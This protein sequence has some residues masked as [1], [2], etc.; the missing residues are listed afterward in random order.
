MRFARDGTGFAAVRAAEGDFEFPGVLVVGVLVV[1]VLAVG[2]A[3]FLL[4]DEVLWLPALALVL[5]VV[6]GL[7]SL[8]VVVAVGVV[9]LVVVVVVGDALFLRKGDARKLSAL[10]LVFFIAFHMMAGK[11]M[12]RLRLRFWVGR[13]QDEER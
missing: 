1:D 6:V 3:F 10:S 8:L 2:V 4:T 12:L 5:V 7:E 13:D 11:S 9:V